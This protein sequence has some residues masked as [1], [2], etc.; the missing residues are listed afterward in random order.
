LQKLYKN[1]ALPL[2]RTATKGKSGLGFFITIGALH[3]LV[4][5]PTTTK[6]KTMRLLTM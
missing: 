6:T 1:S 5:A 4:I 2:I 3:P